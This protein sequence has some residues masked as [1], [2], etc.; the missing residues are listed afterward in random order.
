MTRN[1]PPTFSQDLHDVL[2]GPLIHRLAADL[3]PLFVRRRRHPLALHLGYLAL[4]R[5]I[6]SG[7][8]L[9]AEFAAPGGWRRAAEIYNHG[10]RAHGDGR[11][12]GIYPPPITADTVRHS[13]NTLTRPDHL[14]QVTEALTRHSIDLAVD[15]GLLPERGG[16]LTH[17]DARRTLYGDGTIVRPLYRHDNPG[18]S[19]PDIAKHY[20]H[21]GGH[22]G[23]N[24]VLAYCRGPNPHQRVILGL[25]R[26][27]QPGREAD[28]AT[29][30]FGAITRA[31]HGRIQAIVYDGALR[32][33]HHNQLMRTHGLIVITKV[34]AAARRDR[35]TI[36]RTI[37]LGTRQHQPADGQP[38]T[39]TLAAHNGAVHEAHI[40]DAGELHLSEPLAR[41]Q[42]RRFATRNGYRFS[43]GVTIP[44]PREPFVTWLSPHPHADQLRLIPEADPDFAPLYGLRNDAESNNN[45][46]KTT[47]PSRR[48][49]AL[50]W[51]RQLLDA[52]GW[53]ILINSRA[54]ARHSPAPPPPFDASDPETLDGLQ[55]P[56]GASSTTAMATSPLEGAR[57]LLQR[58]I[59][60]WVTSLGR[61]REPSSRT[62]RA[63]QREM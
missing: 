47:L 57:A 30:L 42:I 34:H 45:S 2:A 13:R 53:A 56:A 24:L 58:Q 36:V 1:R 3:E 44:C 43:L 25:D 15:I 19:D 28:T 59:E 20:R 31:A 6:G 10:A 62:D 16:S 33:T 18:R 8:R 54:H 14:G 5:A 29:A 55:V 60:A 50:G 46:Y 35:D 41:K 21:D 7:N 48:A 39:H 37:P 61:R 12:T 38:C 26:V 22:W 51:R 11:T 9:D 4:Q 32:G 40:D 63:R 23:N 27:E 52:A 49:A 17:P